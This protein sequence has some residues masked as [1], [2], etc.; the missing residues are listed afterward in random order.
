MNQSS[1]TQNSS[2]QPAKAKKNKMSKTDCFIIIAISIIA[3][4]GLFHWSDRYSENS[5]ALNKA[6]D[7][8]VVEHQFVVATMDGRWVGS[9]RC[10]L[11]E[12][13]QYLSA[14]KLYDA[15]AEKYVPKTGG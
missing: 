15:A 3:A 12:K 8:Y 11:P 10:D 7:T 2:V 9:Y 6:I 4:W 5:K 1:N 13:G 14:K